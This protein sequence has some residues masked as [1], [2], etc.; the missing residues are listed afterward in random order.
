MWQRKKG[1]RKMRYGGRGKF[2]GKIVADRSCGV[3][4]AV[5]YTG[6]KTEVDGG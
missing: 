1:H 5:A 4:S 6:V 3:G 2:D